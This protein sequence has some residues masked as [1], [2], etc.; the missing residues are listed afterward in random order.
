MASYNETCQ[1]HFDRQ[2]KYYTTLYLLDTY[3]YI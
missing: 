1:Y 2:A 3:M